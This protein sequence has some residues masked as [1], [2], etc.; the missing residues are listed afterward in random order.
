VRVDNFADEI[1]AD[2]RNKVLVTVLKNLG[3]IEQF[4]SGIGKAKR[5]MAKNGN[6]PIIFDPTPGTVRV[7]LPLKKLF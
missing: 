7:I 3:L 2:Y 6:P 1:T 5:L 4:G